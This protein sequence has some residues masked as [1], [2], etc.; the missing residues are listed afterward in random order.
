MLLTG[1]M[2]AQEDCKCRAACFRLCSSGEPQRC[3]ILGQ[4]TRGLSTSSLNCR[5]LPKAPLLDCVLEVLQS[6]SQP[7]QHPEAAARQHAAMADLSAHPSL[8]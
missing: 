7:T 5:T 2:R 1:Y 3:S 4:C 8:K 6:P